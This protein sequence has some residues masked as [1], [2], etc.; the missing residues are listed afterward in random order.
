MLNIPILHVSLLLPLRFHLPSL[1]MS[2]N[3]AVTIS[4]TQSSGKSILNICLNI[5]GFILYLN[6]KW[7]PLSAWDTFLCTI[8]T[9]LDL[10]LSIFFAISN[11]LARLPKPTPIS[12]LTSLVSN[13]CSQS[14]ANTT[15]L[16]LFSSEYIWHGGK[17][18]GLLKLREYYWCLEDWPRPGITANILEWL[19]DPPQ[20]RMIRTK[21]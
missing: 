19:R 4:G 8:H 9:A 3:P 21:C 18:L 12:K 6:S 16:H 7:Q 15:L 2:R 20:Q 5:C 13:K 17:K 11:W 1:A 10:G 14:E